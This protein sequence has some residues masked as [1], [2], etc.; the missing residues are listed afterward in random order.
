MDPKYEYLEK[1]W[2]RV[3]IITILGGI[4]S[5]M[6][7]IGGGNITTP[8]MLGMGIDPKVIVV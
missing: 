4:I 3:V 2:N 5:G 1:N 8:L 6:L 7:G